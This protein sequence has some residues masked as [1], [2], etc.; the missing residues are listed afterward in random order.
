MQLLWI[1]PSLSFALYAGFAQGSW[2][3][4]ALSG[5]SAL[6]IVLIT[7]MRSRGTNFDINDPVWLSPSGVAIGNKVLPKRQLFW[8]RA[9]HQRVYE[10]C[11]SLAPVGFAP[12]ALERARDREWAPKNSESGELSAWL[13][14]AGDLDFEVDLMADGPHLLMLGPTGAGKSE[15]LKALLRS[16]LRT[17]NR[18]SIRMVLIDFKGGAGLA[19]FAEHPNTAGL[20][21]DLAAEDHEPFWAALADELARREQL[22]ADTKVSNIEAYRAK[23]GSLDRILVTID[24][25]AAVLASSRA[26][27]ALVEA[28]A[29]RGRSLGFNLVATNQSLVGI[30][31]LLLTNF[32]LR[33]A[34]GDID[35]VDLAQLSLG[36]VASLRKPSAPQPV[37]QLE[38]FRRAQ[39]IAPYQPPTEFWFAV[40]VG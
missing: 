12:S 29:T 33:C 5:S 7:W 10:H 37:T 11:Q 19:D 20:L 27:A 2:Q 1:L 30:P 4:L 40:G 16:L 18:S 32:R 13:G 24:E 6:L 31:R 22:F 35:A 38:G 14:V 9:W 8:K 25:L 21:T 39:W 28:I 17:T 36:A 34:I 23:V 26:A 3:L 15:L